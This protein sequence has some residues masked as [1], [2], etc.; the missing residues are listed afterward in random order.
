MGKV[1]R[2]HWMLS[3]PSTLLKQ[4]PPETEIC[5]PSCSFSLCMVNNSLQW[6]HMQELPREPFGSTVAKPCPHPTADMVVWIGI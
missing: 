3:N 6:W 1:Q 5:D 2:D 4:G